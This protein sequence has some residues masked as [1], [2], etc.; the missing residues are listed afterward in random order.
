MRYEGIQAVRSAVEA[1]PAADIL[2]ASRLAAQARLAAMAW[3]TR[4]EEEWRRTSVAEFDLDSLVWSCSAARK[5]PFPVVADPACCGAAD[6]LEHAGADPLGDEEPL[7]NNDLAAWIGV[8][9][10]NITA[11]Y[12]QEKLDSLGLYHLGSGRSLVDGSEIP[13]VLASEAIARLDAAVK[14]ADTRFIPWA[15]AAHQCAIL[16]HVPAGVAINAPVVIDWSYSTKEEAHFPVL[17]ATTG[18]SSDVSV[19]QRLTGA[20][21]GL[22]NQLS[23]FSPGPNAVLNSHLVQSLDG[24]AVYVA[25]DDSKV[26]RDGRF[27]QVQAQL[28]GGFVKARSHAD[29]DASG[30]NVWLDGLYCARNSDHFDVRSVQNHNSPQAWSRAYYKGVVRDQARAIYQG[31][32]RVDPRAGGTDSYLNN[33]NMLLSDQARVD[34]IPSL[35]ILTNDVK[36]SHGSTT[37]RL[38][39]DELYYLANRGFSPEAAKAELVVAFLGEILDRLPSVAVPWVRRQAEA[40]VLAQ[41][42]D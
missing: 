11:V 25:N 5:E 23:L 19:I 22:V 24:D 6:W 7:Q 36:C 12:R 16:I 14:S 42:A 4:A 13:A 27:L 30:A 9:D 15:A 3:P 37:G 21:G 41:G 29:L 10:G 38:R 1:L 34:S 35:N 2:R 40:F 26:L 18:A 31:M 8:H 33:K 39:D 32:I 28:G 20:G 17:I